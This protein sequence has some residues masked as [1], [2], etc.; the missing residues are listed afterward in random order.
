[1]AK[2]TIVRHNRSRPGHL[3]KTGDEVVI[4]DSYGGRDPVGREER[5]RTRAIRIFGLV[6]INGK[7]FEEWH[8]PD[9]CAEYN[10]TG[11]HFIRLRDGVTL[12]DFNIQVIE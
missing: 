9:W 8:I 5:P 4:V 3:P 6:T 11:Y 1:M 10:G 2:W 12:D 7:T